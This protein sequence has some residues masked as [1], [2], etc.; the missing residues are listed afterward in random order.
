MKETDLGEILVDWLKKN[1]P[2]W[3]VYQ[4]IRPSKYVGTPVADIVCVNRD[5]YVWVI[6]IKKN[7]NLDVIRQ[8]VSWAVDYRSIA[9]RLPKTKSADSNARWWLQRIN[10]DWGVG[11]LIIHPDFSSRQV[12][13]HKTPKQYELACY[14]RTDFVKTVL[15]GKTKGF[16]QAGS[17]EGGYWTPYKESMIKVREYVEKHP[18]C[19]V[20]DI[21]DALGKLHYA[22]AHSA[23]TNLVKALNN[24]EDWCEVKRKGTYD[25]FYAKEER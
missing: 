10:S 23:R 1:K 12:V 20:G 25:T 16:A 18:G 24:I 2:E 9:I 3:E 5:N 7:L 4:E 15:D 11:S 13:E 17:N 8:A 6:E 22:N 14:H 19:G 21:V